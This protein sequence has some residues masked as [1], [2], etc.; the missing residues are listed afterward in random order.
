VIADDAPGDSNA[1]ALAWERDLGLAKPDRVLSPGLIRMALGLL[2][3][4]A[5]H[6]A[7]EAVKTHVRHLYRKLGVHSRREAVQRAR[8]IGLLTGSCRRS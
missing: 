7:A 5:R 1:S 8:A 3:R 2:E 6:R 4:Q